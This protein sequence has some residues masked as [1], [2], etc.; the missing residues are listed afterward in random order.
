MSKNDEDDI[1]L[2]FHGMSDV[3]DRLSDTKSDTK[4]RMSDDTENLLLF[5][6]H[7]SLFQTCGELVEHI[8]DVFSFG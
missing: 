8:L 6:R 2:G 5:H 4:N 1:K 3:K 7:H